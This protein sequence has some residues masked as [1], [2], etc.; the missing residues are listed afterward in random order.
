[1]TNTEIRANK[2]R[3]FGLETALFI[4]FEETKSLF[5]FSES[6]ESLI[7]LFVD[8]DLESANSLR[9]EISDKNKPSI[10]E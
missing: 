10:P 5:I 7:S 2:L 9:V 6:R 8:L 4:L 1:M 3:N